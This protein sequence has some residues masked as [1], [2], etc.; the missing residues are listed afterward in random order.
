MADQ[1]D[2]NTPTATFSP[3]YAGI[4]RS[5]ADAQMGSEDQAAT[6]EQITIPEDAITVYVAGQPLILSSYQI[7]QANYFWI[8]TGQ[9]WSQYASINPNSIIYLIANIPF[10]RIGR[11]L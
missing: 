11:S 8:D 1:Q 3:V 9:G 7:P 10:G 6:P 5:M 2:T 4:A